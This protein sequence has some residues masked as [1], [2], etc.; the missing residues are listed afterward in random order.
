MNRQEFEARLK[1]D[2]YTEIE[3]KSLPPRQQMLSMDILS[4]SAALS[5]R[6]HLRS[7][8]ATSLR[9]I[10][11][12]R[13]FRSRRMRIMQRKLALRV[14]KSLSGASTDGASPCTKER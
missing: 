7:R 1:D 3:A 8:N 11:L 9:P 14:P 4:R 5:L 2:G 13:F 10:A 12:A 6:V